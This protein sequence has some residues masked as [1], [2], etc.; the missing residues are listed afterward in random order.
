M[1]L[2]PSLLTCK[3]FILFL[4]IPAAII[5]NDP[6]LIDQIPLLVDT[7][8]ESTRDYSSDLREITDFITEDRADDWD[9]SYVTE[10]DN[11]FVLYRGS[12][13]DYTLLQEDAS[14]IATLFN[15]YVI[16]SFVLIAIISYY[17]GAC[18]L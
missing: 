18:N 17:I 13:L 4:V 10:L 11:P 2:V 7:S 8:F 12:T 9:S 1:A 14:G 5:G 3:C 16:T 15:P 6:L